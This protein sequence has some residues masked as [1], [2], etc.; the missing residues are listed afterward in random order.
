MDT[1]SRS[2]LGYQ[3]SKTRDVGYVFLQC[4]WLLINL[5][6]SRQN[7]H[8]SWWLQCIS[9]AAQQF[10]IEKGWDFDITQVIGLTNDDPV[11][12]EHRPFKQRLNVLTVLLNH[13]SWHVVM[14]L[15]TVHIMV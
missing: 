8:L 9:L 2:I 15:M 6:V 14:V 10:K 1:V 11:T 4:E 7:F 3:V 13:L 5:R 12:K